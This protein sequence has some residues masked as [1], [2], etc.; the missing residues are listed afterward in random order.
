[1]G[2]LLSIIVKLRKTFS[3][4][5]IQVRL[6]GGY[7]TSEMYEFLEQQRASIENRIK[8][9]PGSITLYGLSIERTSCTKC[10]NNQFRVLMITAAYVLMQKLRIVEAYTRLHRAHS[11]NDFSPVFG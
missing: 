3:G 11:M 7:A 10:L 2:I 5:R 6:D 4:V 9:L 1:M 8:E